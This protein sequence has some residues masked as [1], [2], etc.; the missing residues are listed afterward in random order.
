MKRLMI[1]IGWLALTAG[2]H[3]ES[4]QGCGVL[5][6]S[7][8]QG[9]TL[10]R[11][12]AK[13]AGGMGVVQDRFGSLWDRA[14]DGVLNRYAADGRQL[15]SY[16]IA[17]SPGR[18]AGDKAVVLGD[19]LLLK[20]DRKLYTLSLEAAPGRA[21]SPLPVEATRLS[22]GTHDGWAAAARGKEVFLINATGATRAVAVLE[23]EADDLEIG[24]D[25]GVYAR[26]GG[27][28][29]RVDAAAAERGPWPSPGDRPQWLDGHWFGAAWHGTLRRFDAAL[30]PDPGVVLGGASGSFIGYVE[31]NHELNNGCGLAHLGGSVYAASGMEGILHLMEWLP[32]DR[33]FKIVRRIGAV[34]GCTGLAMD[35]KG[36]VWYHTGVWEW[37]DGPDAPLKHSVPP[38]EDPGV[39]GAA[40]LENDVL[41]APAMRWG[42]KALYA[43]K[44]DGPAAAQIDVEPLPADGVTCA[45]VTWGQRQALLV[46]NRTGR[47][48]ALEI[49][50]DGKFHSQSG[51]VELQTSVPLRELTSLASSG[52]DALLG[53]ADGQVIEFARA[54]NNWREVRRWNSWGDGDEAR[55][56][57]K[58]FL[59]ASQGRLWVADT[60]RQR[61][62]CF[63]PSSRKPLAA[64]GTVDRPGN[65]LALLHAPQVLAVNGRRAVVFDSGNQRLM[66]L[67]IRTP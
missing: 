57:D 43:G 27:N 62:V 34:P 52:P 47:G 49:G 35:R 18:T 44:L 16:P 60:A 22:F 54:G 67:E 29:Q 2:A 30:Q 7:G 31:G 10:V 56:G 48:V 51:A 13:S 9:A 33:R 15:A 1:G 53:A 26:L 8:E 41:V 12:G 45:V 17:S 28:L 25:G 3:A 14:G 58:V 55:F 66:K 32:A 4:L 38:P 64:F 19:V 42:K 11:F 24:P 63:D 39:F 61:V 59:A 65:D 21:P 40:M 46:M 50:P 6:N 23:A 20:L 37:N 36:R 5:G